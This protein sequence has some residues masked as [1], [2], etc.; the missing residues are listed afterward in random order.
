MEQSKVEAQAGKSAAS[1]VETLNRTKDT[2]GGI[3][4]DA[5]DAAASDLEQLRADLDGLRQTLATF[6]AQASEEAVRSARDVSASLADA[7]SNLAASAAERGKGLAG[8]LE[9]AARRN[10]LGALAG[11]LVLGIVIG[12][13]GRGRGR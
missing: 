13:W 4:N 6:L 8:E 1:V 2:L 12:A 3:A 10:P 9:D 5:M 11:A 7:G